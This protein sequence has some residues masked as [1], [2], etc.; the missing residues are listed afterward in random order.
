MH[1]LLLR[2]NMIQ[3]FSSIWQLH[4][5]R[6]KFLISMF[7]LLKSTAWLCVV[8]SKFLKWLD[9]SAFV[10]SWS[11]GRVKV[12]F[13]KSLWNSILHTSSELKFYCSFSKQLIFL[14]SKSW[15][16]LD[17]AKLTHRSSRSTPVHFLLTSWF[18]NGGISSNIFNEETKINTSEHEKKHVQTSFLGTPLNSSSLPVHTRWR[19]IMPPKLCNERKPW[20]AVTICGQMV[21]PY[22]SETVV[23]ADLY[24]ARGCESS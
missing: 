22:C 2:T 5:G 21:K 4:Y 16:M 10:I 23:F 15:K 24:C 14:W 1:F 18:R 3:H 7:F 13:N 20:H 12:S 6:S 8:L 19:C 11:Q 9:T 17:N